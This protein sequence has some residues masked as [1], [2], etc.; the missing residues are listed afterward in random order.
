MVKDNI[1]VDKL[2]QPKPQSED[3][4][5]PTKPHYDPALSDATTAKK[6]QRE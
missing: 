4:Y 1:Q 3:L 2:L 6:R 5:Y